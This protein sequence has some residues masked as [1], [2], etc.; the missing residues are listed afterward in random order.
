MR[1]HGGKPSDVGAQSTTPSKS[2]NPSS[3]QKT[4]PTKLT[5]ASGIFD[6]MSKGKE[7]MEIGKLVL[8]NL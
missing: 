6:F 1:C 5:K 4:H 8:G 7:I 2:L 3:L